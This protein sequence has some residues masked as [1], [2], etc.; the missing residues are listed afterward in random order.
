MLKDKKIVVGVTGGIA[1]YKAANLVS[2]LVKA[3]ADVHVIMTH[4]ATEFIGPVVME[5][6]SGNP[7]FTSC[8]DERLI[9]KSVHISLASDADAFIIAPA[10]ANIVGKCAY[11]IADD[12][13]STTMLAMTCPVFISPAMNTHMYENYVV[14]QNLKILRNRGCIIIPPDEGRLV[15]GSVGLGKFPSEGTIL[16]YVYREIAYEHDLAGKSIVITAGPTQES[17]DPVRYISNHSSGRMGCA[18]AYQAMLRGA[19][20]TLIYGPGTAVP[21]VFVDVVSVVSAQDMFE[22]VKEYMNHAD[23]II[24]AAAVADF[25]PVNCADQKIKKNTQKSCVPLEL[26]STTDILKYVGENRDESMLVCGFSMETQN[27]I[28]SSTSKLFRKK[29]DMIAANSLN[30]QGAGFNTPTNHLTLI[31]HQQIIDVPLTTK[32]EAADILLTELFSLTPYVG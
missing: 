17:I 18:L 10:T 24:M 12:V 6:L 21:P 32:E 5:S 4:E 20:V 15:C 28:E 7:C 3:H 8:H 26:T 25:T 9:G 13:V 22:A 19:K 27:L 1:A 29:V 2:A 11:G 23:A 31:T 14:Q 30:E 16:A